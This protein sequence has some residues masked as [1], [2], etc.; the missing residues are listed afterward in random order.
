MSVRKEGNGW[1]ADVKIRLPDGHVVRARKKLR[2]KRE[3]EMMEHQLR[4]AL[5]DGTYNAR[6]DE[7][8]KEVPT[9]AE[10]AEEY[11][12]KYS[13]V[14]N[15][16][17]TVLAKECVLREHLLPT[18][19][20]RRIDSISRLNIEG[21][22]AELL[23]KGLSPKSIN[24]ALSVL[25]HILSTAEAYGLIEH[26]PTVH[27]LKVPTP[28]WRFLEVEDV[29]RLLASATELRSMMVAALRTGMRAGELRGLQWQD[30]DFTRGLVTVSRNLVRGEYTTPK[31]GRTRTI[32]MS[33]ELA[34]LLKSER[35]LRG[36]LVWCHE[37]GSAWDENSMRVVLDRT[38]R[39]AGLRPLF[40]WHVF[41]HT[42][43]SHLVMAGSPMSVV[44]DLLG[45][46]TIVMTDRYSHVAPDVMRAAI[47]RL[48]A[49]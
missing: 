43:A 14:N 16:A 21:W 27:W 38:I 31:N 28:K 44:K 23:D 17:S 35:H 22:K 15:K 30:I 7:E 24:N 40:G 49:I 26:V 39:A 46:G 6:R 1:R 2:T 11:Q 37:D 8:K 3:A 36:P 18:L 4:K 47:G 12:R 25:R 41:R 34:A 33:D 5:L 42:F 45:H 32:P 29:R 20:E 10:W 13:R 19:G 48:G 9:L